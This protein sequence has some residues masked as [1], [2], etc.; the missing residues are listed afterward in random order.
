[1][2][3]IHI[4]LVI[5]LFL[6]LSY[7]IYNSNFFKNP[8]LVVDKKII[9]EI[10][11]DLVSDIQSSVSN[12]YIYGNHLNLSGTLN[13]NE[14][15]TIDS[16]KLVI[17]SEIKIDLL[18]TI[19]DK[20]VNFHIS[21]KVNTGFDLDSLNSGLYPL[22]IEL[23]SGTETFLYSIKNDSVAETKYY[24][25][26]KEN[27]TN[28]MSILTNSKYNTLSIEVSELKDSSNIYDIVIDPGHGGIDNGAC[29]GDI[30]ETDYTLKI[31]E[32]IK[33]SLEKYGLKIKLTWD[34]NALT[35]NDF[36]EKYG[37][38]GRVTKAMNSKA[39]YLFSIHMNKTTIPCSGAEIY[40]PTNIDYS[41]ASSIVND[42]VSKTGTPFSNN[43]YY[44]VNNGIY[45]RTFDSSDLKTISEDATEGKYE[46]YTNIN[47]NTPYYFMIRETGGTITGAYYDGRDGKNNNLYYNT[48]VGIESY[49]LEL[50]Y[51]NSTTDVTNINNK[52]DIYAEAI[53]SQIANYL[54]ISQ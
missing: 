40:T 36:L 48:N 25:I 5:I 28:E 14:M 7:Y 43:P 41:L 54:N 1:M 49:I 33:S 10:K 30:C 21:D 20:S 37:T 22:Y 3:R 51:I 52:M 27:I 39:K 45:T 38:D 12:L 24:S 35:S 11:T 15:I 19:N 9:E 8:S 50:G 16:L 4:L 47:L 17:N 44:K 18:H 31:S 29:S 46:V 23:I 53:A 2:K 13:L 6:C 32:K 26:R 34:S 42:I